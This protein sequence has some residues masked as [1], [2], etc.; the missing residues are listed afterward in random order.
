MNT[1]IDFRMFS[2][3]ER[4]DCFQCEA[5]GTIQHQQE[6]YVLSCDTMISNQVLWSKCRMGKNLVNGN[7]DTHEEE[8][9][10]EAQNNVISVDCNTN[11]NWALHQNTKMPR[12]AN[13][14]CMRTSV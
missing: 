6:M 13:I 14:I 1:M 11:T 4:E 10:Q 8:Y 2:E 12:H 3:H 7:A 5:F 9:E